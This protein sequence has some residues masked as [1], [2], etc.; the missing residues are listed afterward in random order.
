VLCPF[1]SLR[2]SLKIFPPGACIANFAGFFVEKA[3]EVLGF[4]PEAEELV[5][6]IAELGRMNGTGEVAPGFGEV[7]DAEEG[8]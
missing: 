6:D 3:F 4:D 8:C 5:T 2:I 7:T 1:S